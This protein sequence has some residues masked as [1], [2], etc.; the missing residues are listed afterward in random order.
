MQDVENLFSLTTCYN[1]IDPAICN[2]CSLKNT[3]MHFIHVA[4]IM[5][6][7]RGGE[8]VALQA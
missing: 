5:M 4:D 1:V 2:R 6:Y 8:I 3:A 7:C